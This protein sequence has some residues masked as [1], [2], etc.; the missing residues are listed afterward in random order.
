MLL[1][2]ISSGGILLRNKK[3]ITLFII[4]LIFLSACQT[5]NVE[6]VPYEGKALNIGVVGESPNIREENISFHN[7]TLE[8]I[9]NSEPDFDAV[10]IMEDSLSEASKNKFVKMYKEKSLPF[11]FIGSKAN[12]VPFRDMENPASYKEEAA[13]IN[14][15]DTYISGFIYNQDTN[16]Y[17]SWKF[18]YPVENSELQTDRIDEVYSSVFKVIEK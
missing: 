8:E 2:V 10:F 1:W 9:Y 11:F 5:N 17:D 15:T 3:F 18:G 4:I 16:E 6:E 7:I 14:D 13:K 12:T